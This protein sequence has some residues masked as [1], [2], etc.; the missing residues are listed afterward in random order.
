[1]NPVL[2]TYSKLKTIGKVQVSNDFNVSTKIDLEHRTNSR[3]TRD[4][5]VSIEDSQCVAR[6]KSNLKPRK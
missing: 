6:R 4:L 5:L 1:M 3:Y 2:Q